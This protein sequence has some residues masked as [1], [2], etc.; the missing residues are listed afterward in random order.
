MT[1]HIVVTG[2]NGFV[3]RQVIQA[4]VAR[5]WEA[6]G[7]VRHGDGA[8]I[9]REAGGRP[10]LLVTLEPESLAPA[11]EGATAVVHLAQIG[12]ERGAA[13]Y[14]AVNVGGVRAVLTAMRAAGVPRI[15]Y[16]SGLGVAHYGISA[17]CTNPYF[18]SKLTCEVD[19]F[20]S[21]REVVVFRPS[22]IVGPGGELMPD[23]LRQMT[24]GEVE[25]VGDGA[26]RLQPIYVKDAAALIL[27][28]IEREDA[29]LAVYDLV[30]PEALTYSA[31]LDRVA[32][33]ARL[34][35][36]K[37]TYQVR[38]VPIPEAMH[39]A[40]SGGYRG[41]FPDELDCLLC[42]EVSDPRPLE[43]LLGGFL[44]PLDDALA[45]AVRTA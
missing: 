10:R 38:E 6:D 40:S 9:V 44:T 29:R 13:T 41:M 8:R 22:Y 18:L 26:Y 3:G 23:L 19:L 4:A 17:R 25:C 45:A 2:A 30:G 21:G 36:R 34:Q 33:V 42:D 12:S 39:L 31:F 1:P 20:R 24:A 27:A 11:F 14:E 5:G 15:V 35:G 16:L 32:A 7:V 28:A 37:L 43:S